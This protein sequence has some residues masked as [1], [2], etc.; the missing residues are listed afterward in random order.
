MLGPVSNEPPA[1]YWTLILPS[2]RRSSSSPN[3]CSSFD[4]LEGGGK[5]FAIFRLVTFAC[6]CAV[7]TADT[8]SRNA[9]QSTGVA[10][11]RILLC[12]AMI[13][14]PQ[15]RTRNESRP[16][17]ESA[18]RSSLLQA[19]RRAPGAVQALGSALRGASDGRTPHPT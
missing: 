1:K 17:P 5:K 9:E 10:T 18:P 8:E 14:P 15:E 16:S 19:A 13:P 12:M 2:E 7:P 6:A 4:C 11:A 3:S